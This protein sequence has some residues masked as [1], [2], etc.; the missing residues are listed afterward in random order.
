[1]NSTVGLDQRGMLLLYRG[2]GRDDGYPPP[3][4]Q[5][6]TCGTTAYGSCRRQRIWEDMGSDTIKPNPN[7]SHRLQITKAVRQYHRP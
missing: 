1:M 5:I 2:R 4:A 7:S 3:P 6:R